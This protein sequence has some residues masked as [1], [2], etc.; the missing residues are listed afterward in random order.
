[1]LNAPITPPRVPLIDPRTGLIDR[2]WYL[3]F[4][5]L[6]NVATAVVDDSGLTF[7]AESVI[8]SY[9]AALQALAQNVET[10]PLPTDL[11]VELTK[12]IEAAGLI[13]Q[14]SALLSQVAELQ[15]QIEA[16][17]S[18]IEC[19]CTELTAELQKQIEGLQMT[20]LFNFGTMASEN[21]GISGTA[22]LAKITALGTDGSLTFTNGIITAYVA[23]T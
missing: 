17:T 20:P 14:S 3:F 11:S 18:Q 22:A 7:S 2:A 21:I 16:L 6:N 23:P 12:Q 5:S 13:D 15:K 1:M 8:A 19:P 4:L 10:Q 9:D